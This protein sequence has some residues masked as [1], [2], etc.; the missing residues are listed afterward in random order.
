VKTAFQEET[1]SKCDVSN[2]NPTSTDLGWNPVLRVEKVGNNR[3]ISLK[4]VHPFLVYPT[5]KSEC[6]CVCVC[7]CVCPIQT[8][9]CVNSG[10]MLCDGKTHSPCNKTFVNVWPCEPV[11]RF[12]FPRGFERWFKR[13][14]QHTMLTLCTHNILS[15]PCWL[16]SSYP[17]CDTVLLRELCRYSKLNWPRYSQLHRSTQNL[18]GHVT[19]NTIRRISATRGNLALWKTARVFAVL[20]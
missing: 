3:R 4:I 12:D 15:D 11:T 13:T 6:V 14:F 5:C 18:I 2:T 17:C 16:T 19:I 7:V 10:H 20:G 1:L 9:R 8:H